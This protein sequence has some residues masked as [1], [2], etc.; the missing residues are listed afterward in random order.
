M[1]IQV[2][3]SGDLIIFCTGLYTQKVRYKSVQ[4]KILSCMVLCTNKIGKVQEYTREDLPVRFLK[5]R[6][7]K[8]LWLLSLIN[9][10]MVSS[11]FNKVATA[12]VLLYG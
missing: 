11:Q 4:V 3:T 8:D 5:N 1:E 9:L 7:E 2:C 12:Y 6:G 10:Y